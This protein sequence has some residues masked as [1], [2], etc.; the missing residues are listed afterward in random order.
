MWPERYSLEGVIIN[1][2]EEARINRE[3]FLFLNR[4][5]IEA[6]KSIFRELF[7]R[8]GKNV[9]F[10]DTLDFLSE[11]VGSYMGYCEEE[12]FVALS[13]YDE[14]ALRFAVGAIKLAPANWKR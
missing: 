7:L 2:L 4:E 8:Y 14:H 9:Q 13:N 12:L 6:G 11:H 1:E 10:G 5:R 3:E